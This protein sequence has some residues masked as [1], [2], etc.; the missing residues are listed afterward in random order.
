MIDVKIVKD[1]GY[2]LSHYRWFNIEVNGTRVGKIRVSVSGKKLYI[3]SIKICSP[4]Q[5]MGFASKV[6]D[7]FKQN[8]NVIVADR[9]YNTAKEFWEKIGFECSVDGNYIWKKSKDK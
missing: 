1:K 6:I 9:V 5:R 4:F 8:Y 3:Y 7:L 2:R